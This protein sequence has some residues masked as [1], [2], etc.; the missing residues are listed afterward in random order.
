[1]LTRRGLFQSLGAAFAM[2][3]VASPIELAETVLVAPK[4]W[5]PRD[6]TVET[7]WGDVHFIIDQEGYGPGTYK[8]MEHDVLVQANKEPLVQTPWH[9]GWRVVPEK[10]IVIRIQPEC[11]R[12]WLADPSPS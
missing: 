6:T 11:A 3:V 12:L 7:P 2:A 5:V 4:T 8:A 9:D 10:P 1:M